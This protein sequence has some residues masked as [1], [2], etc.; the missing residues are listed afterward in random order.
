MKNSIIIK[1]I[2]YGLV[3]ALVMASCKE[4]K[5]KGDEFSWSPS[6]KKL[7]MVNVESKELLLVDIEGDK[8]NKITPIDTCSGEKAKFYLPGWSPDGRYLLYAKSSK[9]AV[10]IM[11]YCS[12]ENKTT[13]IDYIFINEKKGG[14]GKVFASWSPTTNRVLWLS[15]N[16]LAEHLLFSALPDGKNKKLLIKLIGEK[17]FPFPAW[18]PD[19]E[20]IAYSVYIKDGDPKNGL[21]KMKYD[22][23]EKKQIFSIN[24]IT[25]FQWQPDGSDLA[26]VYKV[27]FQRNKEQ[28]KTEIK[29]H[30]QLSL[31][32]SNGENERLL[33]EER[34][35][36]VELAWSPD[37][38]Q[39]T[40]FQVQDDSRDISVFDLESNRKVKLNFNKVQNFYGWGGSSQLFYT[41]DYPEELVTQTKEQKEMRELLTSLQGVQQENLFFVCDN[42]RQKKLGENIFAFTPA[43]DARKTAYYKSFQP[44]ILGE[45]IYFPVIEFDNA[46]Q[47][48]PARTRGQH[49]SAADACYLNQKYQDAL[50]HLSQ[51]WDV[52]LNS[53]DFQVI[54]DVDQVIEKMTTDQDSSQ[55]VR[56]AVG[57]K[58]GTLLRTILILRKLNQAENA[59]WL[60]D[61]VQK[62]S[63]HIYNNEQDKKDKLDEIFWTLMGNYGRYN[64]LTSGI[65]D[66]D[67]FF[68]SEKPDSSLKTY[69]NY[70]QFVMA[71]ENRQYDVALEKMETAIQFLPGD[72]AELDDIADLL[73]LYQG[74]FSQKQEAMLVPILYQLINRFPNDQHISQI[75]EMLGDLQLKQDHRDEALNAYQ[76]AVVKEFDNHEIWDKIL[77]VR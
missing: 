5:P 68:Q 54:F 8:I 25:A 50:E 21:W 48:Y 13:Q 9:T 56:I 61:Q 31:I 7:A 28:G 41:T 22:G 29:Y 46:K 2:L 47:F 33:S 63:L 6:G 43:G 19:G 34:L 66:L 24:E 62:L 59:D 27:I 39:L 76:S 44:A 65:Q 1:S 52:D 26:V 23:S 42:F 77:E 32:D 3:V 20:W 53:P 37:G 45:E 10:E 57:L 55:F 72:L 11:V 74:N 14:D 12:D 75:Y 73:R 70:A 69:V 71:F 16:N 49:V 4:N 35:Q 58:N 38:T 40:F 51:Y 64:E 67:R 36:I 15:W 60:F 18:S 17:V 30:Y